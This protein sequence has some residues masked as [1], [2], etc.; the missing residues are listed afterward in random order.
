[1]NQPRQFA[2]SPEEVPSWPGGLPGIDRIRPFLPWF[3]PALLIAAAVGAGLP[4]GG[5]RSPSEVAQST[6]P[7]FLLPRFHAGPGPIAASITH[8]LMAAA[9]GA[10]IGALTWLRRGGTPGF[11]FFAACAGFSLSLLIELGR[12]VKPGPLPDFH[13]PPI[14]PV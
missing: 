4:F 13:H 9:L 8:W 11:G 2:T 5:W 7:L 12:L 3:V 6:D 1:M 14:A 10:A